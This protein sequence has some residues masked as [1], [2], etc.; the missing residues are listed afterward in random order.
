MILDSRSG[1]YGSVWI[2]NDNMLKLIFAHLFRSIGPC[3]QWKSVGQE[4]RENRNSSL[5]IWIS[6][7]FRGNDIADKHGQ[8]VTNLYNVLT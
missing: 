5:P 8:H 4:F 1:S 3:G 2:G 6:M 7:D